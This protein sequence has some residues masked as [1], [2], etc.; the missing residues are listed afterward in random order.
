MIHPTET[1]IHPMETTALSSAWQNN[2]T[3]KARSSALPLVGAEKRKLE[4]ATMTTTTGGGRCPCRGNWWS[5][6]H[7][8]R[9]REAGVGSCRRQSLCHCKMTR[10]TMQPPT[11]QSSSQAEERREEAMGPGTGAFWPRSLQ[12]QQAI[13]DVWRPWSRPNTGGGRTQQSTRVWGDGMW[14][15][16]GGGR[17]KGLCCNFWRQ[18]E[19][20]DK[21]DM[22]DM[23]WQRKQGQQKVVNKK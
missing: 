7:P 4:T 16:E 10:T 19:D 9:G 23:P 20:D 2:W 12:Q 8:P 15:R 5:K 21:D 3:P 6:T 22:G 1:T 18:H 11:G 14:E 17:M 13:I